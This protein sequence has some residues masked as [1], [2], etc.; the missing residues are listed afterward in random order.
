M[1]SLSHND[2]AEVEHRLIEVL[3][4]GIINGI[5]VLI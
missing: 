3:E 5:S 2:E 1:T 4:K